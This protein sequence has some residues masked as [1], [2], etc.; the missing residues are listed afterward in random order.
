[1]VAASCE[2]TPG[3]FTADGSADQVYVAWDSS[4]ATGSFFRVGET[5]PFYSG[6]AGGVPVPADY[7]GDLEWEPAFLYGRTWVSSVVA[8]PI[9]YDPVGMPGGPAASPA[10][11]NGA[12]PIAVI[13]VPGDYDGSGKAVPDPASRQPLRAT[14]GG[15][16]VTQVHLRFPTS[17]YLMSSIY[18]QSVLCLAFAQISTCGSR[19]NGAKPVNGVAGPTLADD[20]PRHRDRARS[21]RLRPRT[22]AP[23]TSNRD[24]VIRCPV[25]AGR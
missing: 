11:F 16:S 13:P 1:M 7:N 4:G 2:A 25:S 9:V 20:A 14:L 12:V 6:Q 19:A 10:G 15:P 5:T 22:P 18:K 8:A 17:M 21:A 3:D 23:L 24:P